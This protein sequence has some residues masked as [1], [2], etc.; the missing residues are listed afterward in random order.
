[1]RKPAAI[2]TPSHHKRQASASLKFQ[3]SNL[4]SCAMSASKGSGTGRAGGNRAG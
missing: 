4:E 1:M 2:T 3:I